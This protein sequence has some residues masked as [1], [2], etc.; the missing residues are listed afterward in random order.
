[1][2]GGRGGRFRRLASGCAVRSLPPGDRSRAARVPARHETLRR[3]SEPRRAREARRGG[4][5]VLPP[6][7]VARRITVESRV[8]DHTVPA[9]LYG[10]SAVPAVVMPHTSPI[11][12]FQSSG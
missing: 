12:S 3:L 5:G 1:R 6:L 9:V 2:P 8:G 7:R 11:S 10:G 4:A